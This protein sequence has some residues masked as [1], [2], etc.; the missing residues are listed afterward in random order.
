MKATSAIDLLRSSHRIGFVLSGGSARCAFQ[1]G[2]LETL[3]EFG[4][5]PSLCVGV[6]AGSWNAAA[7]A[8][9]TGHRIRHYWRSFVRMPHLHLPNLLRERS[10]YRFTEIHRR[11]F[12]RYIG[13][14]RLLAPDALPLLVGVTRLR[15][16]QARVFD[17]REVEDPLALLLASNYLPP[18]FTHA[19]RIGGERYGDGGMT[20]NIPY[21]PAFESG[22]DTVVLLSNKGESE[23]GIYR[24]PRETEHV[25]PEPYR[26]RTVVIRPRHRLPVSF[27]ERRWE[28]LTPIIGLGRLRAREV[29]LGESHPE[30]ELRA[31]G[32]APT[33]LVAG[34]LRRASRP[35]PE[36]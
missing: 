33:V 11:N 1:I 14:E 12:N 3:A 28:V 29:L 18:F 36:I 17:A 35:S 5:R 19:P 4:I 24:N 15:D 32:R 6:S 8:A 16:R 26:S 27:T 20:D 25:I 2:A 7:L 9:G 34:L 21:L 30:T 13:A 31:P 23:G 22:C 10:P